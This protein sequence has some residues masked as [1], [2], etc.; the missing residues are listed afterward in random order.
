MTT[1]RHRWAGHML[2]GS[3]PMVSWI[4][5]NGGSTDGHQGNHP[6]GNNGVSFLDARFLLVFL[7]QIR[8]SLDQNQDPN[9][10]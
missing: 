5:L 6:N 7:K 9:Y 10:C 3:G 4:G 1:H 2:T 8:H